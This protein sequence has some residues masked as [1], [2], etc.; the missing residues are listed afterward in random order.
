[1]PLS[2][3]LQDLAKHISLQAAFSSL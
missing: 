2:D 3:A 1:M